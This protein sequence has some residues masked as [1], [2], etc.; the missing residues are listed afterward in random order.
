MSSNIFDIFKKLSEASA[1]SAQ[2][3]ITHLVVGLGNPGTKYRTTR[4]NAGAL[5][6]DYLAETVGVEITESRFK[7]Y[8]AD[9]TVGGV[10]ALLMKPQTYMNLSGEAVVEAAN[11]YKIPPERIIVV[12]DDVNFDVG[13]MRIRRGGSDGG[14]KGL[15][16]IISCLGSSDFPRI[17]VGIGRPAV[18]GF[19]MAD[20]VLSQFSRDEQKVLFEL[21]G[22]VR[23][24]IA[25]MLAG[26]TDEAMNKFSK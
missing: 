10:R 1:A 13:R 22:S 25:L 26:K 16:S 19:E 2:T 5:A 4:H 6:L 20:W 15:R 11:F 3:P 9:A 21:F 7:S 14:Q 23:D 12:S 18:A 8:V 24:A 17:K